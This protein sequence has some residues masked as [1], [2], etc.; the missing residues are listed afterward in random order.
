MEHFMNL[1][2][3][4]D[5]YIGI[6]IGAF[7]CYLFLM[8]CFFNIS[9]DTPAVRYL[10]AV[11]A[12]FLLWTGGSV[13]MRLQVSPGMQFW[14]H[15]SLL[16]LFIIPV[17]IYGFLFYVLEIT[18]K[19]KLLNVC[20]VASTAVILLN[21]FTGCLLPVPQVRLL[22]SGEV[23][24]MYQV[25]WGLW[26]WTAAEVILLVYVTYLAHKKIG[27]HYE[28]RRKLGPLLLGVLMIFSGNI[29]CLVPWNMDFPFD[30]LGG[31]GMAV[32]LVYIIYKQYLFSFS[33]RATTGAVYFVAAVVAFLPVVIFAPNIDRVLGEVNNYAKQFIVVFVVV[34][35][36][37]TV[38]VMTYA[39]KRLEK[40]LYQK[41]K[42]IVESLTEFQDA[43]SSV[44]NKEELYQMI[45]ETV[46][47]AV[48]DSSARI[49]EKKEGHFTECT[50]DGDKALDA[51]EEARLKTFCGS[52]DIHRDPRIAI[53]KYD[54]KICGFLYV[55]LHR[56]NRLIYDEADCIRQIGNSVSGA[57]KNI[58][59]YEKVYQ[60]SIHDEL[61]GLYN[62]SY[63]SEYLKKLNIVEHSTGMIYL[64]M[65]NFKLYND[66]Y[67]E[68]TGDQILRWC[69]R[70]VQNLADD[71]MSVFRV[72]SNE[73]LVV[74]EEDRKEKL[75]SFAKQV[76]SA[77]LETKDDKPK[78]IQPVT[79]SIGIAWDKSMA[80]SARRLFRQAR[81]A[82]FYAKGNGKNRIE[83]YEK[84]FEEQEQSREKG[85][86]QVTPTIFALM[87]AVDAKDSFTFEH[88]EH[89]SEYAAKLAAKLGLPK[90]DI[91]TA[92]VAG[93]LHDIGKIG[94]PESILKKKGKLTDEEYEVMKTHVENSIEMI[95]FL[96]NMNYVIPAVLSHHERYDGKGYPGG[97][98]GNDIPLLGR[99]LAVCD[100]FDAMV[101]KRAYKD[102]LSVEYAIGE[103]ERGKG[104][105][106]DPDVAQAFVELIEEDPS[107]R[108]KAS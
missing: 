7:L 56:K 11:L 20:M 2:W 102:P 91:Q 85:Y 80:E 58:S 86:E 29:L 42:H 48:P 37:W 82:A 35:C 28:Y 55:E 94:I 41:R 9:E 74:T 31:V 75:V 10:R 5:L 69:A 52:G 30:T 21:A 6:P 27:T 66:L 38:L 12:A 99:I 53:F 78:V 88:S 15:V 103:L 67:G 98:K 90:D 4:R 72:G 40:I 51:E 32:C 1:V 47:T 95:H 68:E 100:S 63:C 3:N 77:M 61:T 18:G 50:E 59:A 70:Q 65:D 87:A 71:S 13:L 17:G 62:R 8:F 22:P 107:F 105:Q 96:P 101:S 14:Y 79:F 49:F 44:L 45:R 36:L 89:V 23:F 25:K 81:R 84:S 54:G 46:C 57:L 97:V 93:L 104:T 24:Y 26:L 92:K 60:V 34:Q 19:D 16:G 83:I 108:V 39:R 33:F 64:D 73:F 106:F 76:Q 43:S